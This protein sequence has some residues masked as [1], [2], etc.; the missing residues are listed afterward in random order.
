V[1]KGVDCPRSIAFILGKPPL[2]HCTLIVLLV[3]AGRWFRLAGNCRSR[4]I[5]VFCVLIEDL[6][7]SWEDLVIA[8]H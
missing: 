4:F 1:S 5:G 8:L 7:V 2:H 3:A 6:L